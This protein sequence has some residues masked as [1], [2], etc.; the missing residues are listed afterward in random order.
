MEQE[1]INKCETKAEA[2]RELYGYD[3]SR[4]RK[5]FDKLVSDKG[6]DI[7]KLSSKP[8]KY[9]VVEKECPVCGT[10]FETQKGHPREKHTCSHS[11]SNTYFRSGSDN[12]NW[13]DFEEYDERTSYYSKKYRQECFKY[14][15]KKCV[16]CGESKIVVVHHF[17]EDKF[18]NKPE[19]LI[20]M[21]PTH[22]MYW[23]SQYKSEVEETVIK[24]RDEFM[25]H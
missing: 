5:K 4:V 8:R 16:V 21:C 10:K 25:K 12:G 24:Y 9:K 19:N 2:I 3:N 11:C 20:P 7:T 15:E 1:I 23:H 22:H 17:D 18:N 6:L 13:K 14:H